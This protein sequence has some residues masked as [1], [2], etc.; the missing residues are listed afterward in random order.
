MNLF[1]WFLISIL[2]IPATG[3]AFTVGTLNLYHYPDRL[4]ERRANLET[5]IRTRGMPDIVG[6]QEA[7]RW[8]TTAMPID[9][10]LQLTGFQGIY[11]ATNRFGIV[12]EGIALMSRIKALHLESVRLP[13]TRTFSRQAINIGIYPVEAGGR[14]L[15][16]NVHLSPYSQAPWRR[17]EQIHFI[18]N[19]LRRFP[20]H[21]VIILGDFN[22]HYD[23]EA[24]FML[25]K[26]GFVD[27]GNGEGA[28]YD[29]TINPFLTDK[30]TPPVRLDYIFYQ[31]S[32]LQLLR[33]DWLCRENWVSDH[34]GLKAEFRIR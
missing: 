27:I 11:E 19:E 25:R 18:L 5:E 24:M 14:V 23:S 21:P 12:T 3:L 30:S 4:A 9:Y 22:D 13:E 32:R 31:P 8:R 6:L 26:A 1:R 10:F 20:P 34:F 15:V 2:F 29:P 28:T 17:V 16:V 7:A 33:A